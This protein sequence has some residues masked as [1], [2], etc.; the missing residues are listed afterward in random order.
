MHEP[1]EIEV[2]TFNVR[3]GVETSLDEVAGTLLRMRADV[4][5]LQEVGS[6]WTMGD[7]RDQ[8]PWLAEQAGYGSWR[9]APAIPTEDGIGAYGIGLLSRLP[10]V[11]GERLH[12]LPRDEDEQRVLLEQGVQAGAHRLTV[13]CTHLSIRQ[14]ERLRQ[15]EAVADRAAALEGSL[16]ILGDLN[17]VPDSP[18]Y[19]TMTTV[20]RDVGEPLSGSASWTFSTR[21]PNRR[22]DY[23]LVRGPWTVVRPAAPLRHERSSD[24]FPVAT[25]LQLI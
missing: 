20:G 12:Q 16:L 17:D 2:A 19:D 18:V 21:T 22:I 11:G 14:P 5:A 15:A 6:G 4:V 25:R 23:I 7:G 8:V 10:F 3:L 24:H 9:F 13:L 1:V